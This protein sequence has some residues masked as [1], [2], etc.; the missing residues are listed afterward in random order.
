MTV[1][2]IPL[3]VLMQVLPA[4]LGQLAA[5]L[6]ALRAAHTDVIVAVPVPPPPAADCDCGVP[7]SPRGPR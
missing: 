7:S 1:L 4:P 2:A 5:S 3:I 6:F